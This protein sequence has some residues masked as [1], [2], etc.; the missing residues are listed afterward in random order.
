MLSLSL[1]RYWSSSGLAISTIT[2]NT[3]N[4]N[5]YYYYSFDNP[6]VL[7]LPK[8]SSFTSFFLLR[9]HCAVAIDSIDHFNVVMLL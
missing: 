3:N 4:N 5:Y 2:N 7:S 8:I 9:R 1:D 6:F